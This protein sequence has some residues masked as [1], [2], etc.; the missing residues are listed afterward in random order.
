MA[1]LARYRYFW[2]SSAPRMCDR[3][4]PVL[5]D[6][7]PHRGQFDD[8]VHLRPADRPARRQRASTAAADRGT[9][10]DEVIDARGRQQGAMVPRVSLLAAAPPAAPW[11]RWAS[12]AGGIQGGRPRGVGGVHSQTRLQLRHAGS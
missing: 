9:V 2:R 5:G 1:K 12:R 8:L 4:R 7:G 10:L 11:L 6:H 3:Q